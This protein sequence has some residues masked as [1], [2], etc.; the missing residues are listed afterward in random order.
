MQPAVY[1]WLSGQK[2]AGC[3]APNKATHARRLSRFLQVG[4]EV[5]VSDFHLLHR[6]LKDI[7]VA[8]LC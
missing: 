5:R 4:S 3:D 8:R 6:L 1:H 2:R 7:D